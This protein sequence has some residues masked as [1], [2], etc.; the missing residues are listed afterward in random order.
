MFYESGGKLGRDAPSLKHCALVLMDL[1]YTCSLGSDHDGETD[2]LAS[3]CSPNDL[4]IMAPS[5]STFSPGDAYTVNPWRF[6][7]CSVKQ[8]KKYILSLGNNK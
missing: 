1:V 6:S 4:F 5:V 8:F 7:T 2:P 3:A